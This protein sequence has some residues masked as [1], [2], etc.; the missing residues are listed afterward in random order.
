[1]DK[2]T[3]Q[4]NED[5]WCDEGWVQRAKKTVGLVSLFFPNAPKLNYR[6][7]SNLT[8]QET[9]SICRILLQLVE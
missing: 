9:V 4:S 8:P 7:F 1:L 6:R 5:F 3:G 2:I